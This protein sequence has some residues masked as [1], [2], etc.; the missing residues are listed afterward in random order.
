[1]VGTSACAPWR[2]ERRLPAVLRSRTIETGWLFD[3]R[4]RTL[5]RAHAGSASSGVTG[6]AVAVARDRL[7]VGRRE[8]PGSDITIVC[9]QPEPGAIAENW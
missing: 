9:D 7:L 1:M 8:G 4:Q 5:D 3:I 6:S 2:C